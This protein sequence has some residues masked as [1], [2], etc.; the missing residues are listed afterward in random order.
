MKPIATQ[1]LRR[2]LT[3]HGTPKF[4][5][6]FTKA[7]Q[8]CHK[9]DESNPRISIPFSL[10]KSL[11]LFYHRY[12]F[13]PRIFFLSSFPTKTLCS[14]LISP[15]YAIPSTHIIVINIWWRINLHKSLTMKFFRPRLPFSVYVRRWLVPQQVMETSFTQ[16]QRK[17]TGTDYT[18][19]LFHPDRDYIH[20][21]STTCSCTLNCPLLFPIGPSFLGPSMPPV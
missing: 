8:F 3:F 17:K 21:P 12:L 16:T 15:V 10:V 9:P 14:F 11:I 1:L 5:T 18:I 6:V 7:R 13:F 2:F 4:I 19:V 20:P